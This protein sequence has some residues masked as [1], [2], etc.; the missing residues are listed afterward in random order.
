MILEGIIVVFSI[1]KTLLPSI[2]PGVVLCRSHH[3]DVLEIK[4]EGCKLAMVLAC[5]AST[6]FLYGASRSID[7]R[8]A[9]PNDPWSP[10]LRV[11]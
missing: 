9:A 3:H 1:S 5:E 10:V 11:I 4:C 2:A 7:A 8:A 6:P